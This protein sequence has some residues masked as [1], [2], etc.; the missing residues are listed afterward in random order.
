MAK[1]LEHFDFVRSKKYQ[2]ELW[3]DGSIWEITKD[4]DFKTTIT[5]MKGYL[6]RKAV[7]EKKRIRLATT[8]TTITFQFY[9]KV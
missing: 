1:R 5:I 7:I 3:L 6:R 4:T 8:D 2:W 9:E